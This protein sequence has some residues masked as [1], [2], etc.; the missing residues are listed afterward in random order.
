MKLAEIAEKLTPVEWR[1]HIADSV[2]SRLTAL[3]ATE[4]SSITE[5]GGTRIL[6]ASDVALL[7]CDFPGS[8]QEFKINVIPW[9]AVPIPWISYVRFLPW[10]DDNVEASFTLGLDPD[11]QAMYPAQER[12]VAEDFHLSVLRHWRAKVSQ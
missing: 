10:T 8:G 6:V 2:A 4:Q 11:F 5:R 1:E 12:K 3:D 9:D 7:D